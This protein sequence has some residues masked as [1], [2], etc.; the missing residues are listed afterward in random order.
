[1]RTLY[2]IRGLPG[3]GKSTLAR[4]LTSHV[5][6][7]DQ[8]FVGTDGLY[9]FDAGQIGAAHAA[10]QT[11]VDRAMQ[12]G[13]PLIAVANTFTERW[14]LG[15]YLALAV[16]HDYDVTEVTLSGPLRPNL[17]GVPEATIA[18]MRDRWQK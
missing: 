17:H 2:L 4:R 7:A 8:F 11:G 18:T 16:A 3:S 12:A 15:P 1:V 10:C 14:E 6:E 9:R 13:A 5:Y